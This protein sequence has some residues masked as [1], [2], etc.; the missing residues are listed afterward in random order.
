[1]EKEQAQFS[2]ADYKTQT[3]KIQDLQDKLT[4]LET[5]HGLDRKIINHQEIQT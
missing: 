2:Q 3:L 5:V 4:L 1:M